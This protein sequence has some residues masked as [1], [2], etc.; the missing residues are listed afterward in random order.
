MDP[1]ALEAQQSDTARKLAPYYFG[2][3][4]GGLDARYGDEA[5]LG[6]LA[7]WQVAGIIRSGRMGGALARATRHMNDF[8]AEAFRGP[9]LRR[10]LLDPE[11]TRVAVGSVVSP[12]HE[13]LG[14]MIA[15]W[16]L[17]GDEDPADL[18]EA[19]YTR[20]ARECRER[21]LPAPLREASVEP[22]ATRQAARLVAGADG[23][24]ESLDRLVQDAVAGLNTQVRGWILEADSLEEIRIPEE[25]FQDRPSRI[26]AAAGHYQPD[27][28]P[29]GRTFVLLVAAPETRLRTAALSR[30]A[31]PSA[32]RPDPL[33]P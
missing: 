2:S 5:A 19:F 21:G 1:L 18:R 29:W 23:P 31:A 30:A 28:H 20:V 14:A 17:Y 15:S 10:V 13:Y 33:E 26:A 27:H 24:R 22:L 9:S 12:R 7:G 4:Y 11:L 3:Y 32:G 6:L 8:L 16:A 25:I